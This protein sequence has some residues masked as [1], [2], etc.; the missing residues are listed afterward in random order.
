VDKAIEQ[1]R[2]ES[3]RLDLLVYNA[4]HMSFGPPE[5]FTESSLQSSKMSCAQ[6]AAGK[7]C[8][9]SR[10]AQARKRTRRWVGSSSTRGGT[11]P[12]LGPDFAAKSAMDSL[13]VTYA[14]ELT[15]WGIE[16][17]IVVP[18]VYTTGTNHFPTADH[19]ADESR[20]IE[21]AYRPC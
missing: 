19:P 6:H 7:P 17:T 16:T 11:P 9:A 8:R 10:H 18:G 5:A 21:Y 2:A 3:G 1:I 15:R 12:Y 4:G 13:A 20:A 14:G